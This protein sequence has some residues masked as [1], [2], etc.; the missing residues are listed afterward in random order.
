M[1]TLRSILMMT[2]IAPPGIAIADTLVLRNGDT[3]TGSVVRADDQHLIWSSAVLG[4]LSVDIDHV[5]TVNGVSLDSTHPEPGSRLAESS[6][7]VVAGTIAGELDVGFEKDE[8]S[9]DS[10]EIEVRFKASYDFGLTVGSLRVEHESTEERGLSTEEDYELELKAERYAKTVNRGRY[11][12]LRGDWNKDRFRNTDEWIAVGAGI[13]HVWQPTEATRIKLQGGIDAWSIELPD[14]RRSAPGGRLMLDFRHTFH[15]F[16]NLTVFSE[17][18]FVWELGGRHN[19]IVE[20]S[21][22]LRFPFS[23]FFYTQFSLDYD[24]FESIEAP[25]LAE[26]DESEWN[27]RMGIQWD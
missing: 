5:A 18:Q 10:E 27:F 11:W 9:S 7:S 14:E 8:G 15:D 1:K 22:G 2:V 4:E 3:L 26:N 21:S 24:R 20:T 16:A 17:A 23:D 6:S 12:Y 19:H 25:D 13:G